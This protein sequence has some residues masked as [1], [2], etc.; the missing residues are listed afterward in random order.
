M[1]E[2]TLGAQSFRAENTLPV[3]L[4]RSNMPEVCSGHGSSTLPQISKTENSS[5]HELSLNKPE[6]LSLISQCSNSCRTRVRENGRAKLQFGR[7]PIITI[8][9][10]ILPRCFYDILNAAQR[11]KNIVRIL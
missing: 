2:F 10:T 1:D 7:F 6:A 4:W 3:F 8:Y 5:I 11:R 9:F